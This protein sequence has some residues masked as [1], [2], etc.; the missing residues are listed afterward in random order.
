MNF[1]RTKHGP[2]CQFK[3]LSEAEQEKQC[4]YAVHMPWQETRALYGIS[5][6]TA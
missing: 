3:K 6:I 2:L 4:R 5:T 1:S